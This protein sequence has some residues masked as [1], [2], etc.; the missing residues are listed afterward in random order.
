M[1]N[2]LIT[3]RIADREYRIK[4]EKTEEETIRLAAKQINENINT[5]A[6]NF[7]YKDKQDL[8]AMVVLQHAINAIKLEEQLEFQEKKLFGKLE[9]INKVLSDKLSTE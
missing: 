8:L 3:V 6:E 1:N 2:F 4:I 7:E 5:Y 9:E